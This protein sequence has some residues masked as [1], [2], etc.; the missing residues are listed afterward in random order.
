MRPD[1]KTITDEVWTD[2]RV[3]SFLTPVPG[4]DGDHPDF[5]LLLRAYRSM[6]ADD[7]ARYITVFVAAGHDVH[8]R[9]ERGETFVEHVA[10]HRLAGPFIACITAARDTDS[11][12]DT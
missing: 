11:G 10:P 3:Q 8:A 6:R 12:A 4:K 9:N 2:E 7:F 5:R 1:K